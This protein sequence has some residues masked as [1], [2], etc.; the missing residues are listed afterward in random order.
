M[1]A[2]KLLPW[3]QLMV[4]IGGGFYALGEMK[5][6]GTTDRAYYDGKF[7]QLEQK[8]QSVESKQDEKFEQLE[9]RFEIVEEKQDRKLDEFADLRLSLGEKIIVLEVTQ[10]GIITRVVDLE[11]EVKKIIR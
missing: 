10:S 3:F 6:E 7:E 5:A 8:F 1:D 11:D 9:K 4:L 2:N